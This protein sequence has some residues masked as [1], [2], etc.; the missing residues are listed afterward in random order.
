MVALPGLLSLRG[1]LAGPIPALAPE[2]GSG[3]D[4]T[5]FVKIAIGTGGHGHTFPGA[6]VPSGAVQLSPDTYIKGWDWCS[7]YHYSDDSIMRFSHTY[8]SSTT[9]SPTDPA[10]TPVEL[11]VP[12]KRSVPEYE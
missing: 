6:P 9:R 8:L 4:L 11:V 7:G 2:N 5:R 3:E 10:P 1:N 12:L